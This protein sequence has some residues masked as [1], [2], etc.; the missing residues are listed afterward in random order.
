MIRVQKAILR[1][2]HLT[3]REP[4][5]YSSG[6]QTHRRIVLLELTDA[7]GVTGWGEC[8][9]PELPNYLPE[10]IDIAW[11]SIKEWLL[12]RT[13][14]HPLK[15]PRE[16]HP[17]LEKGIRG[18]TMARGA[19]EMALWE[20]AARKEGTSLSRLLGGTRNQV[21]TGIS[22]G[23]QESPKALAEKV[24]TSLGEGYQKIKLKIRPG[25]DLSFVK[26]AREAAGP[27]APLMVDANA[28]YT[29]DDI[30]TF[31]QLDALGLLM[32]EQPLAWD[33]LLRHAELQKKL[34]TPICLDESITCL[35]HAQDMI[36]LVSGRVI[37]I[38]PARVGGFA[39]AV[40]IHDLCVNHDV[41]VW[42]GGMLESGIGR[43][44]NVALAS[45]PNF[46]IP[47]DI[48]PSRRYWEQDIVSPEWTMSSDGM[49]DVPVDVPGMGVTVDLD[50]VD[51]ITVRKFSL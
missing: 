19:V 16:A 39:Q 31:R 44:H 24:R 42:C 10:T 12:P 3:L 49:V 18:H 4:F 40:A 28:T 22:I 17:L 51:D 2:I 8:V 46:R 35:N 23:I 27:H 50:H 26:E 41:P 29:A 38:K 11:S 32:V 1:E 34:K 47:G 7:D 33:D 6:T 15:H 25:S 20:L 9:A 21:A 45:L 14:N 37:N 48:S 36:A 13:L 30:E 43:A 5:T